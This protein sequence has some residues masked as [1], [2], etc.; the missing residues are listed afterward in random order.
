MGQ[1]SHRETANRALPGFRD[2]LSKVGREQESGAHFKTE[3]IRVY[4]ESP[5]HNL[6]G[7]RLGT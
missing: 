3:V 6:A 4:R 7:L 2:V 5:H 1:P